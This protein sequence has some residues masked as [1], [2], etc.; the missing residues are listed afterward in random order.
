MP[1]L[2]T[3]WDIPYIVGSEAANTIDDAQQ[4]QAERLDWLLGENGAD[5]IQAA[6]AGTVTKRVNYA[7]DYTGHG[8]PRAWVQQNSTHADTVL[9][10]TGEDATGFTLGL[11]TAAAG[12]AIRSVRWFCR[13]EPS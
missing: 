5:T 10:V 6:G 8:T 7:R 2:T 4:A 12:T 9:Y 11:R 1:D 13:P 3:L